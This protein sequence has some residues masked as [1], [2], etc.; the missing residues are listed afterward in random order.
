MQS[1]ESI[2]TKSYIGIKEL[3]KSLKGQVTPLE[4]QIIKR[5][6]N[7]CRHELKTPTTKTKKEFISYLLSIIK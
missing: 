7:A 6:Q 4:Y 2:K 3:G 1:T 5:V